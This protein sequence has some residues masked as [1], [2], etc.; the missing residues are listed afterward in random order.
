M[1]ELPNDI[2][3]CTRGERCWQAEGCARHVFRHPTE[4]RVSYFVPK[5]PEQEQ[6]RYSMPAA[7]SGKLADQPAVLPL[8]YEIVLAKIMLQSIREPVLP[9]K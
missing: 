1:S 3:R 4:G 6:V 2:A 7:L 5:P 9:A 8:L